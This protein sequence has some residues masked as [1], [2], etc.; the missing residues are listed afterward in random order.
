MLG[1]LMGVG[2]WAGKLPSNYVSTISFAV[3]SIWKALSSALGLK[4]CRR[5][6]VPPTVC[7]SCHLMYCCLVLDFI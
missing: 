7:S 2:F 1:S 6:G 4:Q 5:Q 3:T